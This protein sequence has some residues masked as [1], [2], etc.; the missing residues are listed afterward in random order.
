MFCFILKQKF[1]GPGSFSRSYTY[2]S[3]KLPSISTCS[4]VTGMSGKTVHSDGYRRIDLTD[5]KNLQVCRQ[6][7]YLVF[8]HVLHCFK[9]NSI[10]L[11]YRHRIWWTHKWNYIMILN[12]E[13]LQ[14]LFFLCFN[15]DVQCADDTDSNSTTH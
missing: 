5:K 7:F 11:W 8:N 3:M 2:D 9:Q 10:I 13:T 6:V 12:N 1:Q 15:I 14:L 4:I